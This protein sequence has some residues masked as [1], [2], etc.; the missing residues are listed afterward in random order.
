MVKLWFSDLNGFAGARNFRRRLLA[1]MVLASSI[2]SPAQEGNLLNASD[3]FSAL[4]DRVASAQALQENRTEGPQRRLQVL[5]DDIA[6]L[7]RQLEVIPP[8]LRFESQGAYHGRIEIIRSGQYQEIARKKA[9]IERLQKE[10]GTV[11][12]E[13]ISGRLLLRLH[14]DF[15]AQPT[16]RTRWIVEPDE[17]L[18]QTGAELHRLR[19]RGDPNARRV[20]LDD[21]DVTRRC[22]EGAALFAL[23]NSNYGARADSAIRPRSAA[24]DQRVK[25]ITLSWDLPATPERIYCMFRGKETVLWDVKTAPAADDNGSGVVSGVVGGTVPG[26]PALKEYEV[27][28]PPKLRTRVDPAYPEQAR[29]QG[30]EGKVFLELVVDET[31]SVIDA[32]VLRSDNQLFER[33]ARSAVMQWKYEPA[34]NQGHPVRTYKNVSVVFSL[35]DGD[36]AQPKPPSH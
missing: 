36:T 26:K 8:R 24:A 19:Y 17:T 14:R 3:G 9:E 5:H 25:T 30:M 29:Q 20:S 11:S 21:A 31:G 1:W 6:K 22:P 27:S 13:N 28:E 32:R 2:A 7:I 18:G 33:S 12:D 4:W 34:R 23:L 15:S 35:H 16:Q 10:M